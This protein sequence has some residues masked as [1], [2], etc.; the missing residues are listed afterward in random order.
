MDQPQLAA[1]DQAAVCTT[2]QSQEPGQ[3]TALAAALIVTG[4]VI[5]VVSEEGQRAAAAQ[6]AVVV[7]AAAQPAVALV[8]ALGPLAVADNLVADWES[9]RGKSKVADYNYYQ[10][11]TELPHSR[12]AAY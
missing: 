12:V 7:A 1:A 4:A 3:D 5:A 9:S 11:V 2:V 6:Q 10:A 8:V